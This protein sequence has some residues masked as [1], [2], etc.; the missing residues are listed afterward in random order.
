MA[1]FE[2]KTARAP[3]IK[4]GLRKQ[5]AVH[6]RFQLLCKDASVAGTNISFFS[7]QKWPIQFRFAKHFPKHFSTLKINIFLKP[8]P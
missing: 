5:L 3:Q 4:H 8:L 7:H 6:I 1:V 2:E